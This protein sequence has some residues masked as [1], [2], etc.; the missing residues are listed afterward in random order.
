MKEELFISI[1]VV[2]AIGG[3]YFIAMGVNY[4]YNY[5]T[6]ITASARNE[7][8]GGAILSAVISIPFWLVVSGFSYPI[9]EKLSVKMYWTLNTPAIILLASFIVINIYIIFMAVTRK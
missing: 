8:M 9:R 4:V 7:Y 6:N 2:A 1:I 3:I 5:F